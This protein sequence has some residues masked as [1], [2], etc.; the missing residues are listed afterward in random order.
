M[1]Y[2]ASPYSGALKDWYVAGMSEHMLEKKL[3]NLMEYRYNAVMTYVASSLSRGSPLF[4]PIL[5]SHEMAK[6][7][8][9]PKTFGFWQKI[10][11]RMIDACS[12]VRI[13]QLEGW[14]ESAGVKDEINYAISKGI[15]VTYVEY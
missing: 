6:K 7:Y 8:D 4:S 10:N 2:L 15:P 14:E 3:N 12:E 5:H 1:I 13:L 11:H 9:L